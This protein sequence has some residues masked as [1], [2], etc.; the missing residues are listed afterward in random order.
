M[1]LLL[2]IMI[3][4]P[5]TA[6]ADE[7]AAA[8][9]EYYSQATTAYQQGDY[10][11]AADLLDL[12]FGAKPDLVYKYNRILALQALEDYETALTELNAMYGPMN[13]DRNARFDDIEQIKAQLEAAVAAQQTDTSTE[14]DPVVEPDPVEPIGPAPPPRDGPNIPAI[15]LIAGG[16]AVLATGVLF[17]TAILLPGDV[18]ECLGDKETPSNC[19][20]YIAEGNTQ[21]QALVEAR[22]VRRTHR[23]AAV[24]LMSAGAIIAGVGVVLLVLDGSNSTASA[25]APMSA[26]LDSL[27]VAPYVSHDGPGAMLQLRF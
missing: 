15:A 27:R 4:L 13:A 3:A 23:I 10:R 1:A 19:E 5:A 16:G 8:A 7:A 21:A 24:S 11:K 22:H 20:S 14:P 2:T 26:G 12:A 9:A 25:Q 18:R 6:W 17:A